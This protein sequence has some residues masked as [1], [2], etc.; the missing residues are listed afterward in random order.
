MLCGIKLNIF[1]H[2][3]N[4]YDEDRA[5]R[6]L[7]TPQDLCRGY[8]LL[9]RSLSFDNQ[10]LPIPLPM[11]VAIVP[12]FIT[13]KLKLDGSKDDPFLYLRRLPLLSCGNYASMSIANELA[14]MQK[15]LIEG[16]TISVGY[17]R[18]SLRS[19]AYGIKQNTVKITSNLLKPNKLMIE[20]EQLS[21][22]ILHAS[23]ERREGYIKG[24]AELRDQLKGQTDAAEVIR[25][26]LESANRMLE[27]QH[28]KWVNMANTDP[29]NFLKVN[30][31]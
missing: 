29:I 6:F 3:N 31:D 14:I 5:R 10:E 7:T 28:I 20:D 15:R 16:K 13:P 22:H 12:V 8:T 26:T 17:L 2:L 11:T 24:F 27:D 19:I 1:L 21:F 25:L 4:Q 23:W 18:H 30:L 9:V